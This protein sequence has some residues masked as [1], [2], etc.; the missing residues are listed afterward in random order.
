MQPCQRFSVCAVVVGRT[1]PRPRPSADAV[2]A[3]LTHRR[4]AK[5]S[6]HMLA[7]YRSDLASRG[8]QLA[9]H[10]STRFVPIEPRLETVCHA[11]RWSMRT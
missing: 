1:L 3:Y 11:Y 9:E 10:L 2:A 8:P 6:P 4:A 5:P 7:R